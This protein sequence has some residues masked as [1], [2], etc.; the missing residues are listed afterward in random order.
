VALLV[1]CCCGA[2]AVAF[3]FDGE[4]DGVEDDVAIKYF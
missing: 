2:I 3:A 4:F 1:F